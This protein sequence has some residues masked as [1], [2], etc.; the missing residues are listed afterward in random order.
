VI[1]NLECFIVTDI[2]ANT[3]TCPLQKIYSYIDATEL[4]H[5]IYLTTSHFT[6]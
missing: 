6:L 4:P 3:D 5:F 2:D 1:L